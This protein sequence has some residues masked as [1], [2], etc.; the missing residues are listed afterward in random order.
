MQQ[1]KILLLLLLLLLLLNQSINHFIIPS[2]LFVC[3]LFFFHC[4]NFNFL[5]EQNFMKLI[6]L[7][8]Y[9]CSRWTH[10][11][12]HM[13]TAYVEWSNPSTEVMSWPPPHLVPWGIEFVQP[14]FAC[15]HLNAHSFYAA[16]NSSIVDYSIKKGIKTII[17]PIM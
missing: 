8:C 15:Y 7:T 11:H 12:S 3:L 9:A 1:N 13:V 2:L 6:I 5:Q 16:T 14:S 4:L 17:R 10:T